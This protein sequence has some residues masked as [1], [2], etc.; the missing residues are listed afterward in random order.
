MSAICK[1]N[2]LFFK[3]CGVI[4]Y[5]IIYFYRKIQDRE[6]F[7]AVHFT[8]PKQ[9][10]DREKQSGWFQNF[11]PSIDFKQV[12]QG[13]LWNEV[14]YRLKVSVP[15]IRLEAGFL[16]IHYDLSTQPENYLYRIGRSGRFGRKGVAIDFATR[17]DERM[18]FD[19]QK[20]YSVMV[21]EL[22][23]NVA[24]LH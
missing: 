20:F 18:L 19:I 4:I 3:V 9:G 5:Q 16:V 23:S 17:D 22:P 13:R 24:D 15:K 6:E 21:E 8:V 7:T 1:K 10:I 12:E 14:D 2:C 11:S